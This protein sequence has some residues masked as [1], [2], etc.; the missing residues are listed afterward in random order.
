MRASEPISAAHLVDA[1]RVEA[2]GRLV[3]DQQVRVAE[4][5][6]GDAEA[7]LHAERVGAVAVVAALAEPDDV[8]QRRDRPRVVAADGGEH[9]QVLPP[10]SAG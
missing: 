5:R 6:G 9:P 7:L 10:L 4:Q 8:E 2:V 1:L 3:E